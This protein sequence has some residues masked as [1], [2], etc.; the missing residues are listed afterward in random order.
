MVS[1][2]CTTRYNITSVRRD[3]IRFAWPR[4]ALFSTGESNSSRSDVRGVSFRHGHLA[5]AIACRA[6][7]GLYPRLDSRGFSAG[8]SFRPRRDHPREDA[9]A[10]PEATHARREAEGSTRPGQRGQDKLQSNPR[11]RAG[12]QLRFVASRPQEEKKW[13][14]A[15]LPPPRPCGKCWRTVKSASLLKPRR[16]GSARIYDVD[17]SG[18]TVTMRVVVGCPA[19]R[20]AIAN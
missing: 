13:R 20:P 3:D 11:E 1:T 7:T 5:L 6:S 2:I 19:R 8:V 12:V 17:R 4:I 10:R 9:R 16:R 14:R 18:S 15:H